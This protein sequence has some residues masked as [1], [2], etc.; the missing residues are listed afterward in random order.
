MELIDQKTF[1]KLNCVVQE[2]D[3]KNSGYKSGG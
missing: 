2:S 3:L 1:A